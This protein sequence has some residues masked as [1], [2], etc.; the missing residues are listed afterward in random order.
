MSNPDTIVITG[1]GRGI[2]L[3]TARAFLATGATVVGTSRTE[4]GLAAFTQAGA[5]LPGRAVGLTLDVRDRASV[6]GFRS[7]VAD[8]AGRVDVLI[9]NAGIMHPVDTLGEQ[10]DEEWTDTLDV[11]LTGPYRVIQAL[12]PMLDGDGAARVIVVSGGMGSVAGAMEGG[13]CVAYRVSKTGLAALVMTIAE[14]SRDAGSGPLAAA[15]DP[16]WVAT[17]LG[18]DD[19]PKQPDACGAELVAL[20]DRMRGEKLSGVLVRAGEVVPW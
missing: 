15:Y 1:A 10:T 4:A 16:E 8:A 5:E 7:G 19:A 11:N 13:G 12:W 18:G 9:C 14:E 17:D 2:G 20:A 6:A 3:A